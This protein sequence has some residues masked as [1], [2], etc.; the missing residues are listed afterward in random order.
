MDPLQLFVIAIIWA[1]ASWIQRKNEAKAAEERQQQESWFQEEPA[2]RAGEPAPRQSKPA[3][4]DWEEELRMLLEGKTPAPKPKPA[5]PAP[6][7]APPAPVVSRPVAPPPPL[8]AA[9]RPVVEPVAESRPA[10]IT[11]APKLVSDIDGDYFHKGLCVHCGGRLLF[12]QGAIGHTLNC[13]HC[14]TDT[15]LRPSAALEQQN[16]AASAYSRRGAPGESLAADVADQFSKRDSAQQAVVA[17]IVFG[18][19]KALE[20]DNGQGLF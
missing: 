12:P 1:I 2:T 20:P 13:P 16:V 18:P 8:P 14:N 5:A 6:R 15:P 7:A 17:S 19:P 3:K 4:A 10:F 11:A 9:P